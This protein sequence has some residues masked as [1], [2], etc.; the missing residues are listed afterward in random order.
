MNLVSI[1]SVFILLISAIEENN[2]YFP[3]EVILWIN[4][5][6]YWK[7]F[8]NKTAQKILSLTHTIP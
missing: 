5:I 7:A 3:Q 2:T 1:F 8:S 6:N 4:N